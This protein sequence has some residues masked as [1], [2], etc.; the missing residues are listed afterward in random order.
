MKAWIQE[1][2]AVLS[3]GDMGRDLETVRAL[4]RRHQG[5]ERDLA[6]VEEKL[7]KLQKQ[8]QSLVSHHP[9]QARQIKAKEAE[10]FNLWNGLK[11]KASERKHVLDEAYGQQGFL[12]DSRDLVNLV[13]L[14]F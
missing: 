9:R 10:I 5:F 3:V 6:A 2:D 13:Y 8:A 1:K 7:V 14:L 12:A 4:Q 11:G